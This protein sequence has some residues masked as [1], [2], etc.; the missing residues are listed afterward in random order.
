MEKAAVSGVVQN[1]T[2]I[3]LF[4]SVASSLNKTM[5]ILVL[6]SVLLAIV[7]LYN[8]TNINVAER[9]RELSTIKVL[10]F[11]NKEVTLYLP[12]DYGAVPCGDCSRF[13][14]WPLF[15]SIFD[16][17]DFTC[18]ILFLSTSQLGSLCAS[19]RRSDCNLSL[20]RLIC[21]S[22]LEKSRYARSPEIS[23]VI[24]GFKQ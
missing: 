2:A 13:D 17:N 20:I 4:E 6:V 7:I 23:R 15:T 21:Q 14:S 11:H 22:P 16:S 18:P 1:V 5:A 12:R 24:Q 10:G 8:L 19:N 3:H 9:I